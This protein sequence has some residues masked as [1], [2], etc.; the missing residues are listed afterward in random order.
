MHHFSTYYCEFRLIGKRLIGTCVSARACVCVNVEVAKLWRVNDRQRLSA[1][2]SCAGGRFCISD[3]VDVDVTLA[4]EKLI[5]LR[6]SYICSM[7]AV[8]NA[9]NV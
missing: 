8:T 1:N 6:A 5:G 7:H 2:I 4:I 9:S 3:D